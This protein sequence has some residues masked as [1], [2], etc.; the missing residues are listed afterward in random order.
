MRARFQDRPWTLLV[1][2]FLNRFV[3]NE[4]VSPE[5]EM[6]I[7]LT[8]ILAL[9][10]VPGMM[11]TF[12]LFPK[13]TVLAFLPPE[14]REQASLIDKYFY[15]TF[16]MVVMGCVTVLEWDALFPDR[17]DFMVLTPLPIRGRVI[18][19]AKIAALVVF[20]LIFSLDVNA[21]SWLLYPMVSAPARMSWTEFLRAYLNHAAAVFGASTFIF[22]FFVALQGTVMNLLSARLFKRVSPYIQFV[23]ILG[24]VLLFFLLPNTPD[25]LD[26][27]ATKHSSLPYWL[28]PMWFVGIYET[29]AGQSQPVWQELAAIGTRAVVLVLAVSLLAYIVSYQRHVKRSLETEDDFGAAPSALEK[30]VT[31][32]ADWIVVPGPLERACFYFVGKTLVRSKKHWIYLA[33]YVGVGF[34]FVLEGPIGVLSRGRMP[35][36][37]P[38]VA[39]LAVPLILSFFLLSGM[40]VI[41]TVPAE[42]LANWV[43]QL[44]ENEQRRQCL[45]GVRKSM[46]VFGVAPLLL[47]V[48]PF[49][50]IVWGWRTTIIHLIFAFLLSLILTELLLLNFRKIPFTCS[51]LPGKANITLLWVFYW[52]CFTVYAYSMASLEVWMLRREHRIAICYAIA[53]AVLAAIV[54]FRNKL[55]DDGFEFVYNDQPEPAVRT[56]DLSHW[57]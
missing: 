11:L 29:L 54:K 22:F 52:L 48:A 20:L 19:L 3:D 37:Q 8:K 25:L 33:A 9:L 49:Y 16:T 35:A 24:L 31:R 50:V 38:A 18:F 4:I 57:S 21:F 42:L 43:F 55:L 41:F 53:A 32:F 5:G 7:T 39:L 17:R 12:F 36:N 1:R 45:A 2:H 30:L 28:P 15:V 10:A 13:Y 34:A 56:L 6:Q 27:L 40:R 14:V 46:V 26:T 44:T 51:Y 47:S 23:S